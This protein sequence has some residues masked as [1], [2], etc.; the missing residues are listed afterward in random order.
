MRRAVFTVLAAVAL[1]ALILS[2][3]VEFVAVSP[4]AHKLAQGEV[5]DSR[6]TLRA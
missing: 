5:H 6:H 4:S 1:L 3:A 2:F